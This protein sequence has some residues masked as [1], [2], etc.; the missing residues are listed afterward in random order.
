ML[1]NGELRLDR[2]QKI[3]NIT[4]CFNKPKGF[5]ESQMCDN[6]YSQELD[7]LCYIES[8]RRPGLRNPIPIVAVYKVSYSLADCILETLD[9][10]PRIAC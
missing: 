4:V 7:S 5:P 9:V 8:L 2:E 10:F 3:M 6:V 1:N